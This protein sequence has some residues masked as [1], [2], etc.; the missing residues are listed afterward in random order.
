MEKLIRKYCHHYDMVI[1]EKAGK[2]K[3]RGLHPGFRKEMLFK[4]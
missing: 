4:F 3:L 2:E 1:V